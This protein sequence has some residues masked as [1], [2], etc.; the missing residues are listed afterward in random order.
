MLAI[1]FSSHPLCWL[2]RLYGL[3][4]SVLQCSVMLLFHTLGSS[5]LSRGLSSPPPTSCCHRCLFIFAFQCLEIH[6]HAASPL[7]HPNSRMFDSLLPDL[8]LY[9]VAVVPQETLCRKLGRWA[10]L[11]AWFPPQMRAI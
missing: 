6:M 10:P 11:F 8:Y 7:A 5:L 4:S 9:A 2:D 1:I 3:L